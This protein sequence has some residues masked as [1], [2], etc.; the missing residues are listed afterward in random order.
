M[1]S[2]T[3]VLAEKT[4]FIFPEILEYRK[5]H[6]KNI[7]LGHLN[8]NGLR[9]KFE[10]IGEI[11]GNGYFDFLALAETK[12]DESFSQSPF[13]VHNFKSYRV[14]RNSNGG[15]LL[16]YVASAIP[17]RV[18]NDVIDI[19]NGIEYLIIEIKI[20][21]VN[22]IVT[23]LYRPPCVHV[24][25]LISVV[26]SIANTCIVECSNLI[27][28]G[29][30][31]VDL[32]YPNHALKDVM[33]N[34]NI[35]NIIK[36]PTCSKS[37]SN[38]SIIDV[39]LTTCPKRLAAPMNVNIGLSDF[40]NLVG[41][42]T[43]LNKPKSEPSKIVYRSFKHFS[44]E[45]YLQDLEMVPFH[46]ADVFDDIDDVMWA[47]NALFANIV[48]EHAPLKCKSIKG[49][50]V[51]YMNGNLR[52]AI[53]VKAM[54]KRK[55]DKDKS[56]NQSWSKY[57]KQRNYV[58]K[59]KRQSIKVY[60]AKNANNC[61]DNQKHFWNVIK[62][63]F[64]DSKSQNNVSS[65]LE[66]NVIVTDARII[67]NTFNEH[68][69][70]AAEEQDE[71]L[72][73]GDM[74]IREI[75]EVYKNHH[76]ISIISQTMQNKQT[77]SFD[78]KH[79]TH[80]QVMKKLNNLKINKAPGFDK[81]QAK[82][83]KIASSVISV[84]IMNMINHSIDTATFPS[85]LKC[86]QV[87]PIY[88]NKDSLCKSNYRPVSVLTVMSKIFESLLCDQLIIHFENIFCNMLSAYRR[89]YSCNNVL[90]RFVE[91][92]KMLLD[93][94]HYVATILMDLSKAFD[95][96]PHALMIAKLNCY[97]VG[98]DSCEFIKSYLCNR[99]QCVK[100]N[101]Q[102][103][104]W[105]I[106]NRGVP[107]GS[108]MGPLLFNI[109]F[110]DFL[111]DLESKCKV[112]NY[113]DDNSI[114][115]Y[116]KNVV[117]LQVKLENAAEISLTWFESNFMKANPTKFDMIIFHGRNKP[118][119]LQVHLGNSCLTSTQEVKL[120]GVTIDNNLS[121]TSHVA[122]ITRKAAKQVNAMARI[123][124]YLSI[125]TKLCIFDT[126]V[127][128]NF[129]YCTIVYHFCGVCNDK[130]LEKVYER[131]IRIVHNDFMSP[132]K[133]LLC[134]SKRKM[135]YDIRFDNLLVQIFKI[136][137]GNAPPVETTLYSK[138]IVKQSLRDTFLLS[139]PRYSTI[140]YGLNSLR[141]HGAIQWNK[142]PK[143]VK[144]CE[145]VNIMKNRL[146]GIE[147][148]CRCGSCVKCYFSLQR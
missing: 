71:G 21:N 86:A 132:Y 145:N 106:M 27:F 96:L 124:R 66:K 49:K 140:K 141:V 126:F 45:K 63:F 147:N 15:G 91:E 46:I 29:D 117:N 119:E 3:S 11:L 104:T 4:D 121:F 90:L 40:H 1:E 118:N 39:I 70:D 89:S 123:S 100:V 22:L 87:S 14:D 98:L 64:K 72:N 36:E 131:A 122:M 120:L 57:K 85:Q 76:S 129:N 99:E 18:R 75:N 2:N 31:N 127:R 65:L 143:S 55:L 60:F 137:N 5:K 20:N 130:K 95:C 79:V 109:F 16:C 54:L 116:D 56:N 41:V 93:E 102:C 35:V 8:I 133:E 42:A 135:L 81:I 125:E 78:F 114:M 67:A 44:E 112:F 37:D 110:N 61:H 50:Q 33:H 53:N 88:K 103:S 111:I 115:C 146:V 25:N 10:E 84:P 23:T 92:C 144:S 19:R 128:S 107:Q 48:N 136:I 58:T 43:R 94:G 32:K 26:E 34:F 97:D 51:P 59:L 47:H 9:S 17:H 134:K 68:F 28:I 80:D 139:V 7:V 12:L 13:D 62:P 101:N 52:R 105:K 138:K 108:L 6:V 24:S 83:L 73:A 38:P 74:S 148:E 142:S 82:F 77:N 69:I 113:A 30:L